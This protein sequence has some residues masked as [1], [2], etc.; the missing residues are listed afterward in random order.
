MIINELLI[1]QSTILETSSRLHSIPS[2]IVAITGG[3]ATG[4]STVVNILRKNGQS[5]LVADQLIKEIYTQSEIIQFLK[6]KK[7]LVL[8][9][10][11]INFKILRQTTF[12]DS[13]FRAELEN[14]LYSKLPE[15]FWKNYQLLPAKKF[16]FYEVPLLFEKKLNTKV[17]LIVLIHADQKNQLKRIELRDGSDHQTNKKIIESQIPYEDKKDF[18]HFI[19]ENNKDN[20]DLELQVQLLITQLSQYFR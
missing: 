16:F 10:H 2:P 5:V 8:E 20:R 14:K 12:E 19:L 15:V 1:K 9:D 6:L 18:A 7:P 13:N 4:K 3:I 11:S 17:D